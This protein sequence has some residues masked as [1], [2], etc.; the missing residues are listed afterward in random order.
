MDEPSKPER[1]AELEAKLPAILTAPK[2]DGPVEMIVRR[3]VENE[4][5]ELEEGEL[6]PAFGLVG[7]MWSVRPSSRTPDRSPHPDMQLTLMSSR[8]LAAIAGERSSWAQAGDQIYVDL[9][10]S[11][12]NLP[13]GTRLAVGEA[14]VEITSQPHTGCR[15]FVARFG[16][17][18]LD[19]VNSRERRPLR[20]RGVYA[21]V[22]EGGRVRVGDR[23][24]KQPE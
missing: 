17:E 10:L 13:V 12:A 9:D 16:R 22:I 4:R 7:D 20:L 15:K 1:S 24:R 5:E 8:V 14:R 23:V 19:F 6:E 18:A 3:P 21:R 11:E 2:D